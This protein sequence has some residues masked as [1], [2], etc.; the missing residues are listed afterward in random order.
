MRLTKTITINDSDIEYKYELKQMSALGL[1]RWAERALCL[2]A[3]TG[4]LGADVGANLEDNIRILAQKV[5][6]NGFSFLG[7]LNCGKLDELLLEL[8][9]KCARR[10]VGNTTIE[11][12]EK[13]IE[14]TLSDI[15]SLIEL[16]KECFL[17]NFP[18]LA[19]ESESISPTSPETVKDTLKQG[20]SVTPLRH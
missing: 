2:V 9:T 17:I 5:I 18:Q 16:E 3:G 15:Q 20:I 19:D 8:I 1:H 10:V 14:N 6:R 13:D 12:T 7:D 11:V 4:V